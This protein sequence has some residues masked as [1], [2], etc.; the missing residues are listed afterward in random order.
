M[1]ARFVVPEQPR[2]GFILDLAL[3]H[4]G[5]AVQALDLQQAEQCL[6]AGIDAPMSSRRCRVFQ[7]GQHLA[8]GHVHHGGEV[9]ETS[10]HRD[11][12]R[13]QRPDV[14][15]APDGKLSQQMGV[16]LVTGVRLAGAWLGRQGLYPHAYHERADVAPAYLA[17]FA[18]QISAQHA[19]AHEGVFQVQL[20]HSSH[21]LKVGIA[22]LAWRG[23][24]WRGR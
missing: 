21:E 11:V 9:N 4:E 1:Q 19:R 8:A 18:Q 2:D 5:L 12:C 22:D 23:V 20:V 3:G 16:N 14:I 13:V 6:A 24:A 17:S 10:S 15:G 7:I